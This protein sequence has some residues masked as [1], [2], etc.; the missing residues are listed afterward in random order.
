MLGTARKTSGAPPSLHSDQ[1]TAQVPSQYGG[2]L[3]TSAEVAVCIPRAWDQ[4]ILHRMLLSC[5]HNVRWLGDA[6]QAQT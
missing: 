4:S 6:K 3:S 1:S 5:H 2:V